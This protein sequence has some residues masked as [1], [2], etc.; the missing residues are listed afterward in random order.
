MHVIIMITKTKPTSRQPAVMLKE[1][2]ERLAE[3]VT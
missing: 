2:K 1:D 3:L